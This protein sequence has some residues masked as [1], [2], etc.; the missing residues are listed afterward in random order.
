MTRLTMA[1]AL[2]VAALAVPAL[3]A[4]PGSNTIIPT[5]RTAKNQLRQNPAPGPATRAA[6]QGGMRA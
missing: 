4:G 5:P 1:T 3:G 2:T 6:P